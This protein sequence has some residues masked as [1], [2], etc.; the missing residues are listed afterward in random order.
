MPIRSINKLNNAAVVM[1]IFGGNTS[2][3]KPPTAG[4][5]STWLNR[6]LVIYEATQAV[7]TALTGAQ[8]R[9]LR[10]F[11]GSTQAG[12]SLVLSLGQ[13]V[14]GFVNVSLPAETLATIGVS[15]TSDQINAGT[16]PT[17]E[18]RI[19]WFYRDIDETITWLGVGSATQ[20]Q[21]ISGTPEYMGIDMIASTITEANALSIV[22]AAGTFKLHNG[23]FISSADGV[24]EVALMVDGV[25]NVVGGIGPE[26]VGALFSFPTEVH[27]SEGSEV[28]WRFV[29]ISGTG[30][31]LTVMMMV[32]FVPDS[33]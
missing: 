21:V 7:H 19:S 14:R 18:S 10:F 32:A 27:V 26:A 1:N 23:R 28:T 31:A 16:P 17:E 30:T 15:N 8:T 4:P 12:S 20:N 2:Q 33:A 11:D 25:A 24:Y 9:T 29:R 3:F 6:D 13:T 22:P 5:C